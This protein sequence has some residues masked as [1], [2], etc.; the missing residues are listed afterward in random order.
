[1]LLPLSSVNRNWL[2]LRY[3]IL[4]SHVLEYIKE[5]DMAMEELSRVLKPDGVALIQV[6]VKPGLKVTH[7]DESITSPAQRAAIFGD[8]GHIRFYG[9][10]YADKLSA[11]G[12]RTAFRPFT[13]LF[14]QR[15]IALYGLVGT[16]DFH[17]VTKGTGI[18]IQLLAF[19]AL[20]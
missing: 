8:P 17:L 6:P 20:V 2:G 13:S 18:L 12:F 9:E 7:E 11:H 4:C 3:V 5:D 10:D 19:M 16:D 1:M 14:T 15:E